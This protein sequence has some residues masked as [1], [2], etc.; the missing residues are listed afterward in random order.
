M[1]GYERWAP[2]PSGDH[3]GFLKFVPDLSGTP[4]TST[5]PPDNV[6]EINSCLRSM[7]GRIRDPEKLKQLEHLRDRVYTQRC[8]IFHWDLQKDFLA[9]GDYH[10]QNEERRQWRDTDGDTDIA[11][12]EYDYAPRTF[13]AVKTSI[14]EES[15][16]W[17]AEMLGT[18]TRSAT[19]SPLQ[20]EVLWYTAEDGSENEFDAKYNVAKTYSCSTGK[21]EEYIDNIYVQSIMVHFSSLTASRFLRSDT[22]KSIREALHM[23]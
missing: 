17:I 21:R 5:R 3:K 11:G 6:I 2:I 20:L 8:D 19:G 14:E 15:R 16:F 18:T 1:Q 23:Q 12:C 7:E 4:P 13:V 10:P 22:R 9:N